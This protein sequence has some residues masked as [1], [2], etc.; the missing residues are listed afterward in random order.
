MI[1]WNQNRSRFHF[2]ALPF[3]SS[4]L[5]LFSLLLFLLQTTIVDLFSKFSSTFSFYKIRDFKN[6]C[7][8]LSTNGLKSNDRMP[9]P[10]NQSSLLLETNLKISPPNTIL[11]EKVNFIF[12]T[13]F[14]F[15]TNQTRNKTQ[16]KIDFL[17]LKTAHD[18]LQTVQKENIDLKLQVTI[19]FFLS[20]FFLLD[21]LIF[22]SLLFASI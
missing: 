8:H 1:L 20:F 10:T 22:Q 11:F 16:N 21:R 5:S 2:V 12:K 19:S 14:K 18:S 9:W 6:S 13:K 3:L 15:K 17:A 7:S 4:L